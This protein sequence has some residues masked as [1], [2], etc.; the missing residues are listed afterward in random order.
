MH[1]FE[2]AGEDDVSATRIHDS[3]RLEVAS[4][5][6]HYTAEADRRPAGSRILRPLESRCGPPASAGTCAEKL[7]AVGVT[8]PERRVNVDTSF[9]PIPRQT[10]LLIIDDFRP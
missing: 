3:R 9:D 2:A 7:S 10:R 1:S 5:V 6:A 8:L 4:L